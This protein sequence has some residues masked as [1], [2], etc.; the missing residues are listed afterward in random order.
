MRF[1]R[2]PGIE[3]D[4]ATIVMGTVRAEPQLWERYLAAGGNCFDTARHYGDESEAAVG[5][6]LERQGGRGSII[7]VGKAA[8][9]P[10]CRPDAVGR[11]LNRTLELLRTDY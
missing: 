11:D 5:R 9:T 8:H 10:D 6:V 3:P 7:V 2:L 4:I 1:G